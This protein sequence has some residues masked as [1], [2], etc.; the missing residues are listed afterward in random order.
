MISKK[1]LLK[2]S[3]LFGL[4]FFLIFLINIKLIMLLKKMARNLI[5]KKKNTKKDCTFLIL[6]VE[7]LS[8]K[9]K[10]CFF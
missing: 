2:F 8:Q 10:I 5:F 6:S 1:K 9:K 7:Q 4:F 3:T